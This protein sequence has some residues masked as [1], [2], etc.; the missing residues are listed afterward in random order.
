MRAGFIGL[1]GWF[2]TGFM[3]LMSV[4][5]AD[6]SSLDDALAPLGV[7]VSELP[8]TPRRLLAA[9]EAARNQAASS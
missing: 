3:G 6:E 7:E 2:F 8:I 9:I 4:A 5:H 1:I